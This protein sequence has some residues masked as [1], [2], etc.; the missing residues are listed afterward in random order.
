[1]QNS[2]FSTVTKILSLVGEDIYN[3]IKTFTH[4][5]TPLQLQNKK[6]NVSRYAYF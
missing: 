6:S 1:M 3:Y 2:Q 4:T 5:G